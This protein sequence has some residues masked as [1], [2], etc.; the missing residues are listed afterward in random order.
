M[1]KIQ[2]GRS[3]VE[4]L[5]VLAVVGIISIGGLYGY[6]YAM[7]RHRANELLNEANKRAVVVASQLMA[8]RTGNI[9]DFPEP[10][11]YDFG[12]QGPKDKKFSLTLTKA[13]GGAI[14]SA[15]CEQMKTLTEDTGIM[16]ITGTCNNASTLTMTFN[17]DLSKVGF[18]DTSETITCDPA[19]D[20]NNNEICEDGNCIKPSDTNGCTKNSDC[21]SWCT[22]NNYDHCYCSI[23]GQEASSSSSYDCSYNN[24]SGTCANSEV[25]SDGTIPSGLV[26]AKNTLNWWSAVNFCK[27]LDRSLITLSDLGCSVDSE[28]ATVTS[29]DFPTGGYPFNIWTTTGKICTAYEY[30]EDWKYCVQLQLSDG[31]TSC[32]ILVIQT[33]GRNFSLST[34]AYK[35]ETESVLCK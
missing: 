18:E 29:C 32:I 30:D 22:E 21:D 3:M 16:V 6:T 28:S 23:T 13:G 5:G 12:L 27:S 24:F 34:E 17:E 35:D 33:N 2:S 31:K 7:K 11:G 19:C 4:M 14:D 20:S 26:R 8:G 15:I 25:A 10:S 9:D 1:K